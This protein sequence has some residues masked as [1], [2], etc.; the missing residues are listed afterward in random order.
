[1]T[2]NEPS[3]SFPGPE[4]Y[5]TD[6]AVAR[7]RLRASGTPVTCAGK[8]FRDGPRGQKLWPDDRAEFSSGS[9]IYHV[10]VTEGQRLGKTAS[11]LSKVP[12]PSHP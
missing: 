3:G 1:M 12:S 7:A 5:S 4:L 6:A 9:I 10:V 11:A 2:D 8:S